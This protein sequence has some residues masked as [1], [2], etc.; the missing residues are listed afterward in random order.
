MLLLIILVFAAGYEGRK[1]IVINS[2]EGCAQIIR[3]RLADID[4]LAVQAQSALA[5]ADDS[6]QSARTRS[7]RRREARVLTAAIRDRRTRVDP[8][9]GGELVCDEAFPWPSVLP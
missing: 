3:D 4:V 2:R 1:A 6:F 9:H 8:A 5:I 7:V